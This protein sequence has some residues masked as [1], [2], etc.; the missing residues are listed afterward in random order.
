M[1]DSSCVCILTLENKFSTNLIKSQCY[2]DCKNWEEKNSRFS[3]TWDCVCAKYMLVWIPISARGEMDY[4]GFLC[5]LLLSKKN[6]TLKTETEHTKQKMMLSE[7]L[8]KNEL[9]STVI[10][11]NCEETHT[12]HCKLLRWIALLLLF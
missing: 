2:T 11:K 4:L 8:T 12:Q 3:D 10:I 9:R 6:R 1:W 5:F 7:K